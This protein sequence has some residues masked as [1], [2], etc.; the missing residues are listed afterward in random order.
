MLVQC[1]YGRRE[2]LRVAGIPVGREIR[3]GICYAGEVPQGRTEPSCD[4]EALSPHRP[5]LGSIIVVV[6]TDAPLLPHQLERVAQRVTLGLGR[7]GS[8]AS[9]SSG[10]IFVAFSTANKVAFDEKPAL[11][12]TLANPHLTPVF[13]AT[14]EATEEAVVNAMIAAETM[15]GADGY[16]VPRLPHDELMQ[17]LRRHAVA[18]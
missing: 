12:K 18:E 6:A 4:S 8:G 3:G 14:A 10:D 1:N 7:L 9:D 17:V 13:V 11:V 2:W 16:R 15:T 5:D